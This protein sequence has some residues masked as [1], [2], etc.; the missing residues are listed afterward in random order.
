MPLFRSKRNNK[1]KRWKNFAHY[2]SVTCNARKKIM[3]EERRK[4]RQLKQQPQLTVKQKK[5]YVLIILFQKAKNIEIKKF[6]LG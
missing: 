2:S 6:Q 5:M 3:T 4:Y 1:N